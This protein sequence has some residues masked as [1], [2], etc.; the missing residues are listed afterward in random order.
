MLCSILQHA[1]VTYGRVHH[2]SVIVARKKQV[3][4]RSDMDEAPTIAVKV[5]RAQEDTQ[6]IGRIVLYK[7]GCPHIHTK[8]VVRQQRIIFVSSH[9]VI[10]IYEYKDTKKR[11][12]NIKL[13]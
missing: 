5:G 11:T 7:Q 4:A 10:F 1:E 8:G 13:A 6:L 9:I 2:Q 3:A 12:R